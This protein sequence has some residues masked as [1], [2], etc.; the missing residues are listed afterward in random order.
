MSKT[1]YQEY[2]IETVAEDGKVL[3]GK[4]FY[5][6]K[7]YKVELL[8]PVEKKHPGGHLIYTAPVVYTVDPSDP[9][10]IIKGSDKTYVNLYFKSLEIL[11][12][13]YSEY[14]E[15]KANNK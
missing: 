5:W 10:E 1:T 4:I 15:Y 14:L 3:K 13:L 7:D 11:K 2:P 6:S 9:N 8:E 12:R